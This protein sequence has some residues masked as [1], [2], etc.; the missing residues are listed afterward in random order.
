MEK[1]A[2]LS[3]ILKQDKQMDICEKSNMKYNA[4]VFLP[5]SAKGMSEVTQ[6]AQ[7]ILRGLTLTHSGM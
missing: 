5:V 7:F 6:I 1:R 4:H 3:R 2:K